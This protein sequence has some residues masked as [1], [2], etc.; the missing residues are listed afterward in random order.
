MYQ[1][2]DIAKQLL[3]ADTNGDDQATTLRHELN[4]RYDQFVQHYGVFHA[5]ANQQAL[6]SDS[7]LYFLRALEK[8][9]DVIDGTVQARKTALFY[10]PTV[11][12]ELP[13]AIG[14]MQP[15][16]ALLHCLNNVGHVNMTTLVE[17]TSMSADAIAHALKGR[18]FTN[19][20]NG[21]WEAADQYLSGNVVA[22]LTSAKA[23]AA[24]NPQY[25][26]NVEALEAVQPA[27]LTPGHIRAKCGASWIPAEDVTAFVLSL[28]PSFRGR[29]GAQ[30]QVFYRAPMAK[31][32][33]HDPNGAGKWSVEARRQWGVA[34]MNGLDIIEK[35]LNGVPPVVYDTVKD[36]NGSIKKVVNAKQ[37]LLAQEKWMH[38][39]AKFET[40][41][42]EDAD[43]AERLC[44]IYNDTFNTQRRRDFD[45]S[46]LTLPGMNR[47]LL[48]GGDLRPHQKDGIY[49][50]LQQK[51]T[52]WDLCVGSGKTF[53][54]LAWANEM[55][56]LGLAQKVM[57]TAPNH[58]VEQWGVE[59][60]RLYPNLKVM[61]M[62]PEDFSASRRQEFLSRMITEDYNVIIIA[63]T[64]FGFIKSAQIQRD[65]MQR[66][67]LKLRAY[68][69]ELELADNSDDKKGKKQIEAK[70]YA[71]EVKL[72][73]AM[74]SL[75]QDKAVITW[76]DL[77]INALLVDEAHEFKNLSI[78]T[79]MHVAGVPKGDAQRAL[80]MRVKTWDI[81]QRGGRV[82]FATGTPLTNSVG[83]A[84]I[85]QTYL[86]E[87]ELE[88][89]G[90]DMFDAW[91]RTFADIVPIFEMTP[92]GGG[93]QVKNRLARFVNLPELF[94]IW[95]GFTFSRS[96]EQLGLPTPSLMGGKRI[97]ITVPASA[98]LKRYVKHCVARVEAIKSGQVDPRNDNMLKIVSDA[99]KAALDIRL[100][101]SPEALK[102]VELDDL[103]AAFDENE[104]GTEKRA[105]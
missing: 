4:V 65:Y 68:L 61:V 67:I 71:M 46:H 91:A 9:V 60:A 43:R 18:V 94:N 28:I 37:T 11:Q 33:I 79:M 45:G 59:A 75:R 105:A 104:N 77:G 50:A 13:L 31:W 26:R 24:I 20:E 92:D 6:R 32:S 16:E 93:F 84:F 72:Q 7:V 2:S 70:V 99:G 88:K 30:G 27:A 101:R 52:L 63:H 51:A 76:E 36:A 22:K 96:R 83:E 41:I 25:T 102:E 80:D 85:M 29:Y 53:M 8:D 103:D 15:E 49:A 44:T 95:F 54:G 40:W 82:V 47:A 81:L 78:A 86:A 39:R 55:T 90:I 57:I 87:E 42:W 1:I 58:L 64:S 73:E 19:P 89:R 12:A 69:H 34:D 17:Y 5:K 35:A 62:A 66:E 97:G 38:I 98:E 21:Q 74:A 23:A 48:D 100:V 56:R 14:S 3:A 10:G